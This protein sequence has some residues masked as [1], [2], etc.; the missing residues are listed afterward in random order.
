MNSILKLK[1]KKAGT[2][3]FSVLACQPNIHLKILKFILIDDIDFCKTKLLIRFTDN[4]YFESFISQIGV[5]F[6][7][8]DIDI[9][10]N[11]IKLQIWDPTGYHQQENITQFEIMNDFIFNAKKKNV[12]FFINGKKSGVK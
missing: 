4:T 1:K 6:K 3:I 8:K 2:F 7:T 10:D 11:I 9:D 12:F 5:D